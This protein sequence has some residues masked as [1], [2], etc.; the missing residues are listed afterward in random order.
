MVNPREI[1]FRPQILILRGKR[2]SSS[3][4]QNQLP[5]TFVRPART[6][7]RCERG[8]GSCAALRLA[9]LLRALGGIVEARG[10]LAPLHSGFTEGFETPDLE[11]ATALL[12]ESNGAVPPHS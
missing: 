4:N 6:R 7:R 5:P 3:I 8:R 1:V 11:E 12:A 9:L 2:F 10:L